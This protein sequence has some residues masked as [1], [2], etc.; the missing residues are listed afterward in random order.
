[1]LSAPRPAL[2]SNHG[3]QIHSKITHVKIIFAKIKQNYLHWQHLVHVRTV[4]R[5]NMFRCGLDNSRFCLFLFFIFIFGLLSFVCNYFCIFFVYM[6]SICHCYMTEQAPLFSG[7]MSYSAMARS[8]GGRGFE[9]CLA[10]LAVP[11][12]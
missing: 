3:A 2:D 1:M 8:M 5:Y 10:L 11:L 12:L 9:C 7:G 4:R 6:F